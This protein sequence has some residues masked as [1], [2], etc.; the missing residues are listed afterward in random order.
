M[1]CVAEIMS[2]LVILKVRNE[3]VNVHVVGLEGSTRGKVN[4]ADDFVDS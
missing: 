3:F 1:D 4:V 2:V